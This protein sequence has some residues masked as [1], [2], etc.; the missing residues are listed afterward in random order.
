MVPQ[1]TRHWGDEWVWPN[2]LVRLE[3]VV[4]DLAPPQ[5]VGLVGVPLKVVNL[6]RT[7]TARSQTRAV[8]AC[9]QHRTLGGGWHQF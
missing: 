8:L 4:V 3:V 9:P 1:L 7:T 6:R 5:L 2:Q